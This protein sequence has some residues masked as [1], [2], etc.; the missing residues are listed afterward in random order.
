MKVFLLVAGLGTRLRPLT[1]SIP[2]CLVPINGKPVID[3]WVEA[4]Q[5][6]G[7]K[8]VLVNLHY[9]PNLVRLHL[10]Q[11]FPKLVFTFYDESILLGSAGTIRNNYNYFK[12]D[13]AILVIYGDNFTDL[14]IA[15]FIDFDKQNNTMGSMGLFISND[16]K[17]CGIVQ[18]N[19]ENTVV[20]FTE[21]PVNP[22]SNLANA[23]LYIFK[24]KA[25]SF[26]LTQ[27][28][29]LIPFDIGF[30]ILPKLV[31]KIKGWQINNYFIDIGTHENLKKANDYKS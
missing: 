28:P 31:G 18:L 16:P 23:G 13:E 19:K 22:K 15:D 9:L 7:F 4:I 29:G 24:K 12:D 25:F 11:K 20:D 3:Y 30:H 17:S 8:E 14:T 27:D 10:T 6:Y 2:K 26:F 21:K 1:N 5:A